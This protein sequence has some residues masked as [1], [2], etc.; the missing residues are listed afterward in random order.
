MA[1]CDERQSSTLG[2]GGTSKPKGGTKQTCCVIRPEPCVECEIPQMARNYYFTGKLMVE[3]DFTDEQRYQMG[4]IRRHSQMLHG[5]GTA[6]GLLVRQHPEPDCQDQYVIIDEG[7]A[8]DCCGR[9]ILVQHE[10][11]FD[12]RARFLERWREEQGKDAEPDDQPHTL[13]ICAGYVECP[14]E[15]V[16]ALFDECGCDDTACMPNRILEAYDFDVLIDSPP[17]A[18]ESSGLRLKRRGMFNIARAHR[19]AV[20]EARDRL[21]V[22]TDDP[23]TLV[24][25]STHDES[26]L[27]T[28]TAPGR[29][30]DLALSANGAELYVAGL[31]RGA[32]NKPALKI[33]VHDTD[34][35]RL[36]YLSIPKAGTD[37]VR[38]AVGPRGRLY[39]LHV[40]E[41]KVFAWKRGTDG[42]YTRSKPGALGGSPRDI[43]VSP[44][45]KH[46][47]I[48][49]A[50]SKEIQVL[51]ASSL[52]V[53]LK[54][55]T[56]SIP[57]TLA[58]VGTTGGDR[59]LVADREAKTVQVFSFDPTATEP[60]VALGDCADLGGE[61]IE[62]AFA[63]G[64]RWGYLLAEK[65]DGTGY[66]RVL[67]IHALEASGPGALGPAIRVGAAARD[68]DV[69]PSGTSL[70]ITFNGSAEVE[71]SG[72]VAVAGALE[73][74]C[75]DL[76]DR[77]LSP[78]PECPDEKCVV[79]ATVDDY[80][81]GDRLVD[82]NP[83][84]GE[85]Q[86]D[87]HKGRMLLPS[88][89][90][91]A[92]VV[93]CIL[94]RDAAA[95][96]A[97]GPQGPAGLPGAGIDAVQVSFVGCEEEG[98]ATI[99]KTGGKRTLVLVIPRGCDGLP[100]AN[101]VNGQNGA[102]IDDVEV[103]FV[104]CDSNGEARIVLEGTKRILR[105][106]LPTSCGQELAHICAANWDHN[107]N[108]PMP[109]LTERGLI[110]AF[111][112]DV[113]AEDINGMTFKV[114]VPQRG[115]VGDEQGNARAGMTCWCELDAKY[116]GGVELKLDPGSDGTCQIT[117][118]I[119]DREAGPVNGA[120]FLAANL[121][122]VN[123]LRVLIEG[124]LVR[125]YRDAR[126]KLRARA[127]D[128]DH[129]PPWVPHR[130]T[131]DGIEGGVFES[132]L[133]VVPGPAINTLVNVNAAD[134]AELATLS[135]IG[136]ELANAIVAYRG[137]FGRFMGVADLIKVSGIGPSIAEEMSQRVT[138]GDEE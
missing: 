67:D 33:S 13:Q 109:L 125:E 120:R 131:G 92:E 102:G 31:F 91:I 98:S 89:S 38:L 1:C 75:E 70:Y 64:G 80:V 11:Y 100:G 106:S 132:W 42:S 73:G 79:L 7:L 115:I 32:Q 62:V 105:I 99:T 29:V 37:P 51:K 52:A 4:K 10:E 137:E 81:Y 59:L 49:D 61:A 112:R 104:P 60:V 130:P 72:G 76:F 126:D 63:P 88:T 39:A 30:L 24:A 55:K 8:V 19:A 41:R 34:L 15:E 84:D 123:M 122:A 18:L 85:A 77:V 20:D 95:A 82:A 23:G 27:R 25:F 90:L 127:L 36:R 58:V 45:G 108:V 74:P 87:N 138:F 5:W 136:P 114:L 96:S 119:R 134:S 68:L 46:L 50:A 94:E 47:L 56:E 110:V 16:P 111:D 121:P 124:D 93:R 21:Y 69:G 116:V 9:E 14:T 43:A 2:P 40:G 113:Q 12:F 44:D 6:C 66:L 53:E 57:Y 128:A 133:T 107:G 86:I 54:I 135:G 78:C 103:E 28:Q 35:K 118:V 48:A 117:D 83:Q 22:V 129:L 65:D 97:E 26:L 17:Q 101:G 71:G 3:R